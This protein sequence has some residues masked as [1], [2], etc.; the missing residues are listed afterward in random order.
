MKSVEEVAAA[1]LGRLPEKTTTGPQQLK[2]E[3]LEWY[4]QFLGFHTAD[5]PALE[6]ALVSTAAFINSWFTMTTAPATG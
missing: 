2:P 5:D 6:D 4:R 3:A 1:I